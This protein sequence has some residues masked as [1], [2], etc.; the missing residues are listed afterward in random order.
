MIRRAIESQDGVFGMCVGG[1]TGTSTGARARAGTA[2]R[3]KKRKTTNRKSTAKNGG[4]GGKGRKRNY[5]KKGKRNNYRTS[6]GSAWSTNER[7]ISSY[8]GGTNSFSGKE[9]MSVGALDPNLG[10]AGGAT[11]SYG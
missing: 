2:A 1:G 11:I 9:Y 8:T 5:R 7:G 10:N 4:R 3:G 6:S